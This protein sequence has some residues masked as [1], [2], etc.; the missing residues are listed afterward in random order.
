MSQKLFAVLCCAV[1]L[2]SVCVC[3][4]AEAEIMSSQL[5]KCNELC[6]RTR[7]APA[8]AGTRTIEPE[9]EQELRLE[10]C[11]AVLCCAVL[12]GAVRCCAVRCGS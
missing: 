12:C 7:R 3:V 6:R 8:M 11:C 10:L 9:Q 2:G 4:P 5:E 1:L